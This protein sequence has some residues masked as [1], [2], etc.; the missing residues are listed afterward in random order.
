MKSRKISSA[1]TLF[2]AALMLTAITSRASAQRNTTAVRSTI[3]SPKIIRFEGRGMPSNTIPQLPPQ[4]P[5][6]PAPPSSEL[7]QFASKSLGL[8]GTPHAGEYLTLTPAAPSV[9]GRGYIFAM[10]VSFN[11]HDGY[12]HCAGSAPFCFTDFY[13]KP[14]AVG[15]SYLID[16]TLQTQQVG[17]EFTVETADNVANKLSFGEPGLQ[18]VLL[19]FTASN[20]DW[21]RVGIRTD[22]KVSWFV[23]SCKVTL[24]N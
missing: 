24:L 12:M 6:K 21:Q 22:N 2:T 11:S 10:N 16:I 18:H 4:V 20:T 13:V 9:A 8:K 23:F 5:P 17:K 7:L 14:A 15:Q 1:A 3:V 19:T